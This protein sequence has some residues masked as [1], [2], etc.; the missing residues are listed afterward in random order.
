MVAL[1]RPEQQHWVR[2]M[3]LHLNQDRFLKMLQE[4]TKPREEMRV[5]Q[6]LEL[7]GVFLLWL[8]AQAQC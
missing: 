4:D 6:N 1:S 5:F 8:G 3:S 2:W 7:F